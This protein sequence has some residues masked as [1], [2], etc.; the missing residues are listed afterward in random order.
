[1]IFAVQVVLVAPLFS[2]EFTQFRG[3]IEAAF[4]TDARFIAEHFPDLSWSPLWYLGFPFEWFYTPLLPAAVALFGKVSGD[5]PHAYRVLSALGFALGP[6]A[7][8]LAAREL[9]RSRWSA[10]IA[11]AAFIFFPSLSYVFTPLRGDASAVSGA[12]VPPPWRLIALVEYGE[13]PHVWSLTLALFAVA[14][15]LRYLRDPRD[16]RLALTVGLVVAVALTNLIGVLGAALYFFGI[17]ASRSGGITAGA[18]WGRLVRIGIFAGLFSLGWYSLGFIRAVF[19]FSAPGGEAGGSFYVA[20]PAVLLVVYIVGDLIARW[21]S[22]TGLDT[23]LLWMLTFAA[24][25]VPQ[26]LFQIA[27]APQPIRYLLELDAAFAIAIGIFFVWLAD[28]LLPRLRPANN[29]RFAVTVGAI[30]VLLAVGLPGWRAVHPTLEPDAGWRSWSERRVALWLQDHLLPGE[31]AYLSGDHAFWADVFADVPQVRGGVDFAFTNPWWAHVTY[32]VNTGTDREISRLWFEALPVRYVVVTDAT[33][34]DVYRDFVDPHKFDGLFPVVFDE[35]GVRIYEVPRVGDPTFAL[36]QLGDTRPPMNAI[37]RAP[38]EAYVAD[39]S[40]AGA[41]TTVM[42]TG[43]ASW[44]LSEDSTTDTTLLLRQAYDSGWHVAVDGTAAPARADAIGQTSIAIPA[45]RHQISIDHRIHRDLLVGLAVALATALW[46]LQRQL[47]HRIQMRPQLAL[48]GGG[49]R[50]EIAI[51]AL[52][53]VVVVAVGARLKIWSGFPKG[54]DA[55]AH[56]TRLQFVADHF[57]NHHW[58]Y[59]WS[60]GMPIFETYPALPYLLGA[61][62]AKLLGAPTALDLLALAGYLLLAIGL[63]HAV[64]LTTGSRLAGLTA[65]LTTASSMAVWTWVADGGVY[66]RVVAAGLGACAAWAAAAWVRSRD[67]RTFV[68]TA[69]L[70]AAS[71][72][73]HQ[74][75]GALAAL[76]VAGMFVSARVPV[77]RLVALASLSFLLGA[78]AIVPALT[79]YGGFSGRFLGVDDVQLTSPLSVLWDPT[80]VGFAAFALLGTGLIAGRRGGRGIVL[81]L[82]ALG[83]TVLYLFAPDFGIPTRSY[84]VNGIAPFSATFLVAIAASAAAGAAI[85]AASRRLRAPGRRVLAAFVGLVVAAQLAI[86]PEALA[87]HRGYPSVEDTSRPGA[88]EEIARRSLQV[89]GIDLAHRFLP[90]TAFESVFFSYFYAKPQLRDYYGTG[91]VHPDWLAWANAAIYTPP[92]DPGR[93]AAALDWFAIDE[94]SVDLREPNFT[95]NLAAFT[96]SPLV[97]AVGDSNP[98][99]FRRYAVTSPRSTVRET[100]TKLLIVV[101]GPQEYDTIARMV[102]EHSDAS[103]ALLP[104]RWSGTV[105]DLP[106]ELVVRAGTIVV[107]PGTLGDDARADA[108]L[109]TFVEHGGRAVYDAASA[110]G[111]TL[112]GIWPVPSYARVSVPAWHLT[113]Q[114]G[115]APPAFADAT[116]DGGAWNAPLAAGLAPGAIADVAQDGRPLIAHRAVGSGETVWIGGNLF[117]HARSKNSDPELALLLGQLALPRQTAAQRPASF[118]RDDPEHLRV[119]TTGSPGVLVSESFHPSWSAR[120]SDGRSLPVAYAG[121]GVMYIPVPADPGTLALSH[122]LQPADVLA[123]ILFGLGALV[124]LVGSTLRR[125]LRPR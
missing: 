26:Q 74:F 67:R 124:A 45:G 33:S 117:F 81:L 103:G 11:A 115:V 80:A 41:P 53:I 73:A 8:Y 87:T 19:G 44:Q 24:I 66:A 48:P 5:I 98:P 118:V 15:A 40:A 54:T 42:Q 120:W 90:A 121:P 50:A 32:Q 125:R 62:I 97:R 76:S 70:I 55:Y 82:A 108:L 14:A 114:G 93:F 10:T 105:A 38:L 9:T 65:A 102:M 31:R 34:T 49:T 7:L 77:R 21:R 4:I 123:W 3:S 61:P 95:G 12:I 111:A 16:R 43:L 17:G 79:S 28:Q 13:G 69:S 56:L 122:G 107:T 92:F 39:L 83:A 52:L 1:M 2:G 89:D 86:A 23:V 30:L 37:D 29:R 88:V 106:S 60:G 22:P 99:I 109:R 68:L 116:F 119:M 51:T 18:R 75:I 20:L 59:V 35:R 78:P 110:P 64:R 63:Y 113:A 96:A 71:L 72:S 91:V 25:V 46:L 104:I 85:G 101:S 100:N 47:R 84:Y 27:L 94:F 58:L 6:V 112:S 57:P 36:A